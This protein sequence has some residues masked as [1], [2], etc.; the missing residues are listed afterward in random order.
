M[1]LRGACNHLCMCRPV[2]EM[3]WDDEDGDTLPQ[4]GILWMAGPARCPAGEL[5]IEQRCDRMPPLLVS[6]EEQLQ[7]TPIEHA[8][9]PA[10]CERGAVSVPEEASGGAHVIAT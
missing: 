8:L 7:S 6:C 2:S 4:V 9:P 3:E 5:P 1:E 10:V